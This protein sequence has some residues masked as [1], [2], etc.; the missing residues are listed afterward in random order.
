[1]VEKAHNITM[2]V[3]GIVLAVIELILA[4]VIIYFSINFNLLIS[5]IIGYSVY[6]VAQMMTQPLGYLVGLLNAT[7]ALLLLGGIYVL[8]HAIKRLIDNIFKSYIA[9]KH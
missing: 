1:V 2:S 7:G 5:G 8:V 3:F 6:G 4:C 9:S